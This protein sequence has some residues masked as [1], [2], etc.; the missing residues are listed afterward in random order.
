M[1]TVAAEVILQVIA[2][3]VA[4]AGRLQALVDVKLAV[5]SHE[6]GV[7][8]VAGVEVD[9]VNAPTLV[10]T[11]IARTVVNI[12]ITILA[13]VAGGAHA[14]VAIDAIIT[15]CSIFTGVGFTLLDVCLAVT[16]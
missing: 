13:G 3:G 15:L 11:R 4:E 16:A 5:V 2:C 6:A 14:G 8:A 10:L 9:P 7:S 1:G 12:H